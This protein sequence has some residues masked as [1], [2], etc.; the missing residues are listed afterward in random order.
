MHLTYL[1]NILIIVIY[2]LL[3]YTE[4]ILGWGECLF[5]LKL[6]LAPKNVYYS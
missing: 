5:P 1:I 2:Y 6:K 3:I 4:L